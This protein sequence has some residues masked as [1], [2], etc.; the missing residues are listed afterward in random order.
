MT[1]FDAMVSKKVSFSELPKL[2]QDLISPEQK[3][4][5]DE[6]TFYLMNDG[7]YVAEYAEEILAVFSGTGWET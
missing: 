1:L 5:I 3:S 4:Y 2:A 6:F 7:D